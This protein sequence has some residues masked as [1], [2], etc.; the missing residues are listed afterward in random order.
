[1]NPKFEPHLCRASSAAACWTEWRYCAQTGES[2]NAPIIPKAVG[3]LNLDKVS[4]SLTH[5][6]HFVIFSSIV[7]SVGNEG[8]R[9]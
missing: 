6:E 4:Q 2:W 8:A 9:A 3:A 1:M 7:S 5:L